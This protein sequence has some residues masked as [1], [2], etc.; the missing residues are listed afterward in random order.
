MTSAS[1]LKQAVEAFQRG[2]LVSARSI[3]DSEAVTGAS[4][5]WSHLLGLIDCREGQLESGIE[6]LRRAFEA[7]PGNLAFRVMLARA[8]TDAG[9]AE[10]ALAVAHA[11]SGTSPGDLAVWHARA[12]AA[13]AAGEIQTA[14]EAWQALAEA[15]PRDWRAWVNLGNALL[16]L[17][18]WDEA[19]ESFLKAG[20]LNP[21]DLTLRRSAGSAFVNAGRLEQALAQFDAIAAVD[22]NDSANRVARAT[23]LASLQRHAEAIA[24]FKEARKIGGETVATEVG[25]GRRYMALLRFDEAT[26]AFRRAYAL[27]PTDRSI[28]HQLGVA[29]ERTNRLEELV[30]VLEE[31]RARGIDEH[32]L[33]FLW[34]VLARRGGRLEDAHAL[35]LQADRNEEPVAWNALMA[36]VAEGLGDSAAAFEAAVAMNRAAHDK[37]ASVVDAEAWRRN[38]NAHRQGLHELARTIT[39]DWAAKVPLLP[40]P[41]PKKLAFLL[42]F[43]RSG[44]TLLDTLLLGHPEVRVLE[45]KQLV[46]IAA[47]EVGKIGKLASASKAAIENARAAY[48]RLLNKNV[49]EDF[50]GVVIDKFPLD[51]ANA[52]LIQA[53]FPGSPIIFAQRH[54]CDVVLSG[55]MQP[56]GMVNFSDIA[57]AA[58]YYDAMMSIWTA[59]REAMDLNVHTVAYEDMV[60]SPESTLRPLLDFLGLEWDE[61]VLDHRSTAKSRGTIITPSYD[62]VTEAIS[63]APVER[64]KRYREQLAPVL[65]ILLPWAE[66]LGYRD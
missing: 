62:Q 15:T 63:T 20:E 42:G 27:D 49:R 61:R 43:P 37:S 54:P 10:E 66:R 29:L 44:T 26:E 35:L 39:P 51:M 8:L 38:A 23:T 40:E 65:P 50:D 47:R 6:R 7:E 30:Q 14:A 3:A 64:W 2:D 52:P 59:S 1:R 16:N 57:D 36:K 24:E 56:F 22:P 45:E 55:F 60:R 46:G 25:L 31:S 41:P 48:E 21:A 34:A 17:E 33:P 11:P 58:D 53:M 19:S 32:R 18:R 13:G 12:E 9:R 4:P 5:Q 28:V